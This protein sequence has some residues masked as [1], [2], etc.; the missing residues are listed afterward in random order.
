MKK[1]QDPGINWPKEIAIAKGSYKFQLVLTEKLD[2][3][4]D[5]F[6]EMTILEIVLWKTNRYPELNQSVINAVNDL[7]KS[8]S[9]G[10]AKSVLRELLGLKG[11]DLPMASAVLRF[12][13]PEEFQIIDQRVYR[14]IYPHSDKLKI[15]HSNDKKIE[16]YFE[17]I[18]YLRSVCENY[19]IPFNM[20]DRI[21]Y[22]LDKTLNSGEPINY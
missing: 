14:F 20:A 11:F 8:F 17:Y 9:H 5:D 13:C 16:I 7:R 21:L 12:A 6:T 18:R 19:E 3:Q 22:Q 1:I 4:I 15:P 2:S 10:K